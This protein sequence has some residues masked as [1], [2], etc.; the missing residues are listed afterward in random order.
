MTGISEMRDTFG[1]TGEGVKIGVI[2][3]PFAN[4]SEIDYFN[5]D[6]FALYH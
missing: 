5:R 1:F 2:D 6:T 4:S 3:Y